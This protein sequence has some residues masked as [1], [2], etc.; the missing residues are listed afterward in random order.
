MNT[1][2]L[3][4]AC[5]M[6]LFSSSGC[7]TNSVQDGLESV[8]N[9]VVES[10]AE[11]DKALSASWANGAARIPNQFQGT[12]NAPGQCAADE[13]GMES[14]NI[15]IDDT[16]VIPI[17]YMGYYLKRV[18]DDAQ[19]F[20]AVYELRDE[21]GGSENVTFSLEAKGNDEIH[22]SGR[23]DIPRVLVRCQ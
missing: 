20:T 10:L 21:E 3:V 19:K 5:S 4:F 6:I 8:G 15:V 11:M 23:V 13:P 14:R 22:V 12:W 17:Y 16:A 1:R 18:L 9:Q 2:K 7:V